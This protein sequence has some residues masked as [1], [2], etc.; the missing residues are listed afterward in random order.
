[1]TGEYI[2]ARLAA[3]FQSPRWSLTLS[4]DSPANSRGDT[5]AFGNPF[6][7]AAPPQT[8]PLRPHTLALTVKRGF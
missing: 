7:L 1:M 3:S 5:F 2:D 8:T 6:S 4:L